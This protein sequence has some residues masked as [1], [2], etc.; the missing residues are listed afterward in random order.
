MHVYVR[1]TA[2]KEEHLNK[3]ISPAGHFL[4]T[5]FKISLFLKWNITGIYVIVIFLNEYQGILQEL[6]S[7]FKFKCEND[8]SSG[9]YIVSISTVTTETSIVSMQRYLYLAKETIEL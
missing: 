8:N 5:S 7:F 2:S 6:I 9:E 3:R 4:F 1:P